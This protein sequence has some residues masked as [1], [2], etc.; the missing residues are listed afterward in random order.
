[1]A[2][3]AL[4][5]AVEGPLRFGD[6]L[7]VVATQRSEGNGDRGLKMSTIKKLLP[8]FALAGIGGLGAGGYFYYRHVESSEKRQREQLFADVSQC[9]LGKPIASEAEAL[10]EI[11]SL[12][13]RTAHRPPE[14]RGN[15]WPARCADRSR[16]LMTAVRNATFIDKDAKISILDGV[17]A[18]TKAIDNQPKDHGSLSGY[19]AAF[20]RDAPKLGL[21]MAPSSNV[22]GP[23]RPLILEGSPALPFSEILPLDGGPEWSFLAERKDKPGAVG[24]CAPTDAGLACKDFP[25]DGHVRSSGLWQSTDFIP[26]GA[27]AKLLLLHGGVL[28]D[29]GLRDTPFVYADASGT[30][31]AIARYPDSP[32]E[33]E[34]SVKV[35]GKKAKSVNLAEALAEV[36]G[37]PDDA[38]RKASLVGPNIFID[39]PTLFRIPVL[40]HGKLGAAVQIRDVGGGEWHGACLTGTTFVLE[41]SDVASSQ[42]FFDDKKIL[43]FVP[44]AA[45]LG[46]C[47][48]TGETWSRSGVVCRPTGCHDPVPAPLRALLPFGTA[49]GTIG[50]RIVIAFAAHSGKGLLV[51]VAGDGDLEGTPDTVVTDHSEIE[52]TPRVAVFSGTRGA[53]VFAE[54]A[55]EVLGVRVGQDGKIAPIVVDWKN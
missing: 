52:K 14:M 30:I 44:H 26:L 32:T 27:N 20:W 10:A 50:D 55:D 7:A 6:L 16:D 5:L 11:T 43:G 23:A 25:G 21:A 33:R 45:P 53:L 46:T 18:L 22:P 24:I 8:L 29:T 34:L 40:D 49:V 31:M 35:Y 54:I 12:E 13:A 17:D 2:P 47:G 38:A 15:G 1:M 39:G 19:V 37:L 36:T 51:R 3:L 28:E 41:R 9:L 42:L 48:R 4:S